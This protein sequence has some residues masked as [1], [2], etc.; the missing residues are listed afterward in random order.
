MTVP[1][2]SDSHRSLTMKRRDGSEVFLK[3][4][5]TR[6]ENHLVLTLHDVTREISLLRE[7]DLARK[8][9]AARN[10]MIERQS[11]AVAGEK[12]NLS[13]LL[14]HLPDVLVTVD[15]DFML[16]ERNASVDRLAPNP[17]GRTC[18]ELLGREERCPD[19]PIDWRVPLKPDDALKV[20]HDTGGRF[21]TETITDSPIGP[22]AMLQFRDTTRE[23]ELIDK[24]RRQQEA[25]T[26]RNET[27]ARLVDF[28]GAMPRAETL[29]EVVD[30]FVRIFPEMVPVEALA[31]IVNDI[32][33]GSIWLT[34]SV[35]IGDERMKALVR[36]HLDR[37]VLTNRAELPAAEVLDIAEKDLLMVDLV[38][39][40]G[41]KVGRLVLGCGE[42]CREQREQIE[43]FTRPLGAFIHN[44]ILLKRLEERANTDPLT[45][46]YNRAFLDQVMEEEKRKLARFSMP[47]A[48]VVA[49]VNRLKMAN[50]VYG[51][52]T[53]DRLILTVCDILRNNVRNTD[54]L[55]RTGG[56]EF[57]IL[58]GNTDDKSAR[59]FVKRLEKDAFRD[60]YM[61][62]GEG[63]KFPVTVSFGAA[64]T[65]VWPVDELI[66]AA[67]RLMYEAKEAYYRTEKRYR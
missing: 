2:L 54:L 67:D 14:D 60:V 43:L 12:E 21:L 1:E 4:F 18:F 40:D 57:L 47:F 63:E 45:G 22:G 36:S 3:I 46:L 66:A 23:I 32:R 62:V 34:R 42:L 10:V 59:E 17:G 56:D 49:D 48:V 39:G 51:H 53:G 20:S 64:G 41:G 25:I 58:L 37:E 13:R 19:C 35:G 27:L 29:E 55:A 28:T 5:P 50:D 9:L 38:G 24:I 6:W 44:R 65:D 7:V 16:M 15:E 31:L 8:E 52:E 11:R 61:E 26:R 30:H 33:P